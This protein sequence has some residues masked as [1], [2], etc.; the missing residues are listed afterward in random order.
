LTPPPPLPP[1]VTKRPKKHNN[2][3]RTKKTSHSKLEKKPRCP[4][5]F[6]LSPLVTKRLK[7]RQLVKK[8]H[9]NKIGN[10]NE[11]GNHFFLGL[12][13]THGAPKNMGANVGYRLVT[14]PP[15]SAIGAIA[16]ADV[17]SLS[18]VSAVAAVFDATRYLYCR[19]YR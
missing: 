13:Q 11:V 19:C 14:L 16:A 3:N 4:F 9:K 17:G 10:A 18:T 6:F 12:R 15:T 1:L 7:T 2:K 8:K 5:S